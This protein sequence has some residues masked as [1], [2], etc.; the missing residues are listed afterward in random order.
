MTK[1][2]V[3]D[4]PYVLNLTEKPLRSLMNASV[5]VEH[6]LDQYSILTLTN[7]AKDY[8]NT[9]DRQPPFHIDY[10]I[11]YRGNRYM[12]VN[13]ITSG[14]RDEIEVTAD[15]AYLKLDTMYSWFELYDVPLHQ[16]VTEILKGTN[17][18]VG[19]ID[20]PNAIHSLFAEDEKKL[21]LLRFVAESAGLS[22]RF[23]TI[24]Y[25]VSLV[26]PKR[27]EK[28]FLAQETLHLKDITRDVGDI[29]ATE[30]YPIG[31]DDVRIGEVNGGKDYIENYNYYLFKGWSI[32]EA[33][34][35]FRRVVYRKYDNLGWPNQLLEAGKADLPAMAF[36][37]TGYHVELDILPKDV[38][39]G[40][41]FTVID[42]MIDEKVNVQVVRM[43]EYSDPSKNVVEL[44]KVQTGLNRN[45]FSSDS[46]FRSSSGFGKGGPGTGPKPE[47][48]PDDGS[49]SG[50]GDG[51]GSGGGG[52]S[53]DG[54]GN[55]DAKPSG[56]F[57]FVHLG[58]GIDWDLFDVSKRY[59]AMGGLQ[60]FDDGSTVFDTTDGFLVNSVH[61]QYGVN[62]RG[63]RYA[64]A[65]ANY[66]LSVNTRFYR[67]QDILEDLQMSSSLVVTVVKPDGSYE[68]NVIDDATLALGDAE[69]GIYIKGQQN[70][71]LSASFEVFE[72]YKYGLSLWVWP[73]GQLAVGS[74]NRL[75]D[76]RPALSTYLSH[77]SCS[78][79]A[80][81]E[82]KFTRDFPTITGP[83]GDNAL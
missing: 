36:P 41:Y 51:D 29:Q 60:T 81:C 7:P 46:D 28:Q 54:D 61:N 26:N 9:V 72:G 1:I 38:K 75:S 16:L 73:R 69:N 12:M 50:G 82:M 44:N 14:S 80:H 45:S 59:V 6:I 27:F 55:G 3:R 17:W 30:L 25:T 8:D 66:S 4:V 13:Q 74:D 20:T 22:L 83:Y 62:V 18:T 5:E 49:G 77:H 42:S 76:G 35:R 11:I 79:G 47:K 57:N 21:H 68:R 34:K 58:K 37:V 39:P 67:K 71:K 65:M 64:V 10:Q 19:E 52:G 78:V 15:A 31:I 63:E 2:N 56:W 70:I 48:K 24:N 43:V 33:R 32:E 23:D 40:D 53:G